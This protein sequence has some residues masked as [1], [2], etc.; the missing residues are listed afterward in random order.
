MESNSELKRIK[1]AGPPGTGKTYR[2]VNHYL[3]KELEEY[4]TP[5]KEILYVGFSNATVDEARARINKVFPGNEILVRTLHSFGKRHA[6]LPKDGLLTGS[7]WKDF[8]TRFNWSNINFDGEQDDETGLVRYKDNMM[9]IIEYAKCKC[10]G[11]DELGAAAF[12]LGKQDS[13]RNIERLEQLY[14]NIEDYKK[15]YKKYEFSDMIK[16]FVDDKCTPSLTAIFVDEAQDLNPLEWSMVKHLET[17]VERSYIAGDDDQAI[18]AFK[19]GVAS[20]FINMTGEQDPQVNSN[21]VP[22]TVHREA[23]KILMNIEERLP[24]QWNPRN[25][26]GEVYS[27]YNLENIDFNKNNWLLLTRT[28]K[29]QYPIVEYLENNNQYIESPKAKLLT[30]R[31]L[32]GWRIW[33]LLNKGEAIEVE[34][35]KYLYRH[36]FKVDNGKGEIKQGFANRKSFDGF[37]YVTLQDLKKDHG[38]KIEGDWRQLKMDDDQRLHIERLLEK[39]EDLH[40]NPRIKVSTIHKMKGGECDNVIVFTDMTE[41]IYTQVSKRRSSKDTEHRIWFVAVT[42]AKQ[43]LF[44]MQIDPLNKYQYIPGKDI[45]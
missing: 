35:A 33:D 32:R 45:I 44:Y 38:L 5:H 23:V 11:I 6:N 19:G 41:H 40:L 31:V 9:K 8:A 1:I 3:R 13:I 22:R 27:N 16:K 17:L 4:K 28:N 34:D 30:T 37:E 26:E 7:K 15:N 2:L 14:Q 18:Y 10:M 25:E 29:Q 39:G 21:R 24:K 36:F 20:T 43:R 12:E 42:R